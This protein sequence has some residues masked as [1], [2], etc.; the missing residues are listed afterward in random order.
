[1]NN[2]TLS[3]LQ[4]NLRKVESAKAIVNERNSTLNFDSLKV[5]IEILNKK[6][7]EH[8]ALVSNQYYHIIT[9]IQITIKDIIITI[10]VMDIMRK[11]TLLTKIISLLKIKNY[12]YQPIIISLTKQNFNDKYFIGNKNCNMAYRN[13][14]NFNQPH[15]NKYV[16]AK[17]V[18]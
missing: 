16:P 11:D 3:V 18:V 4:N 14:N 15:T 7:V 6:L 17:M 13:D 2:I 5:E 9:P 8:Y 10:I 1:M 12:Y